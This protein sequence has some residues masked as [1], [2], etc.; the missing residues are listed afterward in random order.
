MHPSALRL[1]LQQTEPESE[2]PGGGAATA[3]GSAPAATGPLVPIAA[4][5][6]KTVGQ[7][8]RLHVSNIPFIFRDP[9]LSAM[10]GVSLFFF[11]I[12]FFFNVNLFYDFFFNSLDFMEF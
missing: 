12:F 4:D 11:F 8:K 9:D 7:P 3:P 10:F 5:A 2:S 1:V 6:Q